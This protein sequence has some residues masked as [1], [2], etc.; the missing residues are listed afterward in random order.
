MQHEVIIIGGSYAGLSAALQLARARRR[1]LLVDSGRRRNRFADTSHGFLGRDGAS[2]ARIADEARAQVLSYASV[3]WTDGE[4]VQVRG[5]ADAFEV[6]FADGSVHAARRM[7]LAMGVVDRLPALAGLAERWGRQVFVCP[8]C[9]G[10]E[11]QQGRIGVIA[12]SALAAHQAAMLPDWGATWLFLND[13]LV[14]DEAQRAQLEARAVRVVA[15][16]VAALQGEGDTLEL[17]LHDGQKFALDGVFITTQTQISP[18]VTQLACATSDG[19]FGRLVAVDAMQATTVPGIFACGD[20]ANPAASV[21]LAAA[22][23][24]MAGVATHR[25]LIFGLGS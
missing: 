24:A 16:A 14:P 15:G 23:G 25:S 19:P 4:V 18:L 11:L 9:H 6:V 17:V 7:I 20:I 10:Y 12:T 8:Y 1:V 3:Q 2:P 13:T 22:S 21:V 5:Q